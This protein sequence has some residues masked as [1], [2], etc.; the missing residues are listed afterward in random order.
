M[1]SV[2]LTVQPSLAIAGSAN[3][4]TAASVA[5]CPYAWPGGMAHEASVPARS[6]GSVVLAGTVP[7]CRVLNGRGGGHCPSVLQRD[8]WF[9]AAADPDR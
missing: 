8:A 9:G 5:C 2:L 4:C 3:V 1:R 7:G 6:C